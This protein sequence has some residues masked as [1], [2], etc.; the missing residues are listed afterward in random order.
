MWFGT[1]FLVLGFEHIAGWEYSE[2]GPMTM[3]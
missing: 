1:V 2:F 3:K